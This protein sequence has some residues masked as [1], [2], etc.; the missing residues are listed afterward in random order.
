M[1]DQV[2]VEQ[3]DSAETVETDSVESVEVKRKFFSPDE[4]E[5]AT[6]YAQAIVDSGV[7]LAV[8]DRDWPQGMGAAI[9]P[10]TKRVQAPGE[11]RAK[12]QLYGVL[13]T[14]FPTYEAI[15]AHT[16][17]ANTVRDLVNSNFSQTALNPLRRQNFDKVD[18]NGNMQVDLASVPWTLDDFIEGMSTEGRGI[19]KGF[20]EAIKVVLPKLKEKSDAF[21]YL[22]PPLVRQYLSSAAMARTFL[23]QLGGAR[24]LG[25][26]AWQP[27]SVG[28]EGW[29]QR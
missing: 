6:A 23:P 16:D 12:Q 4:I 10:L 1:N 18:E 3:T 26:V 13:Y 28:R 11:D 22:T 5:Q 2:Q 9:L 25:A 29:S 19:Y 7:P 15:M 17:G 8:S 21:K 27:E 24:L 20:N 14:P